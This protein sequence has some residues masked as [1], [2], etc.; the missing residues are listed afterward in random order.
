[1]TN[2]TSIW[3]YTLL[4]LVLLA[5]LTLRTWN[6]RWDVGM[7]PHPDER[8][9][10]CWPGSWIALPESW[11][12]FRD[13]RQSPLNPLWNPIDQREFSFTYGHF[14]LYLGVMMGEVLHTLAPVADALPFPDRIVTMMTRATEGCGGV[15][16]PGR[17]TIA[18]L[19]TLTI[20]FLFLLGRRVYG[21]WAGLLAATFYAFAAQ[22][23]QLSHFFAM[24]PASTTFTV[25]AVLGGVWMVQERS[26]RAALLT[27]IG[28]GLAISSKFSALPILAVPVVA[29]GLVLWAERN[30][31]E[32]RS[33]LRVLLAAPLAL[34]VA[35]L[36]FAV[37]SPYAILDWEN[38]IRFTL[39]EQGAMV[40]GVAD[41][42][43]TRQY[44]NTVPYLYFLQQQI[45]WGLWWPLGIVAAL[46]TFWSLARVIAFVARPGE[47]LAWAWL[48]PYFG[49]TGAFL[50]KF[51]R[52][53][54]PVLPFA[55]LFAAGMIWTL[56]RVVDERRRTTD[57]G[58]QTVHA[59]P[60][61]H[62]ALR[63]TLTRSL[64]VLL[65]TVGVA[66]GLFWSVA[67]VNGV[68]N[69][70]HPWAQAARWM[71]ENVPAGSTVLCEQWDDCMPW[72]LPD[73]PEVN[74]ANS[75]I[76]R[77]DWGPYEEDTAQKYDILRQK[78]LEADYVAYSSKR[79][80]DSVD[81]LP[82]RYP[83]TT[84]YYDLMFSGELGFEV[85]YDVTTP[86]RLFGIEFPDQAA[87]ES[88]SLYDHP[89][90]TVFRKVRDLSDAEF[91]QLL[92]GTWQNA[93]PYYRGEDSPIDPL[94]TALG[95]GS[96]PSHQSSGLL[97]G[98]IAI[99]R[100]EELPAAP[101]QPP[102][103][104]TS[105][106]LDTPL[107]QLP[108]VDDYRWNTQASQNT[109]LAV[110]WWWLVIALLGWLA[111]PIAFVLFRPLRDRGYLLSRALGWLLAGW[112]LWL[113]AG[114][115]VAH[116]TVLN[117]WLA[118]ALLGV[119]GLVALVWNWRE[120]LSF[121][122]TS[123]PILLVGEA[124]FTLA[125]LFFVFVR[126]YNPDIWQPW[127]GGEKFMEFAFLNGILRSPTFPPVDP[128]FAGGFINYYY[129]G[130]Y[131]V[132]YV[133]KLTGIYAEVAFNLAIPTLF[134]L[135]VVN[136]FGVAYSAVI[137]MQRTVTRRSL[138]APT[139]PNGG[140][141]SSTRS[142]LPV[143]PTNGWDFSDYQSWG[144]S[145]LVNGPQAQARTAAAI[146][147][148]AGGV[149][150]LEIRMAN[151]ITG[152]PTVRH[153][154]E[155]VA[156]TTAIPW[157]RGI[158]PALLAP[159]FVAILGNLDAF[160][161]IVRRLGDLST[162]SFESAIP[163]I[164]GLVRALNGL[165]I[166]LSTEARL[167]GYDFWAPSRV[168]PATINEF[169]YWSF[170]FA[171]LHP[172][173]IGI[174][175]SVLFLGLVLTV[176]H[177]YGADWR[178]HWRYDAL[179]LGAFS[180]LL[181]TLAAINLWELPTYFG[182]GV[183]A[184]AVATFRGSGRIDWA[185]LVG[186]AVA[187]LAGAYLLFWPFFSNYEN[188]GASG[189]GLVRGPDDLG[190]W[191]LIWGFFLFVVIGWLVYAVTRPARRGDAPPT[192]LER[193]VTATWRHLD[194][195]PR[196]FVLHGRLVRR[197]SV[198]Y[199]L[200]QWLVPLLVVV[201]LVAA[202][203]GWTVLALCLPFLGISFLLI[204]R[205][206]RA[207]DAGS[208][209]VAL[210]T[211]TGFALLAGTQVVYLRDF[212]QGGDWYRMNT[213]FKFFIQVWVLL[214]IA[215]AVGCAR[216]LWA[217]DERRKTPLRTA[218][219]E[220][221]SELSYDTDVVVV[222]NGR[223][224]REQAS[225]THH[226]ARTTF[227]PVWRNAWITGFLLL[228]LA[229]L[230]YPIVGTPAR[231]DQRF[232]GWR[233]ELG[234]LDGLEFMRQGVYFWPDGNNPIEFGYDWQSIQ[235]ILDNVQ[236]NFVIAESSEMDY[237]RAGGSRI[238][239]MTGL[240]GLS[241]KHAGEQR[242]GEIVGPRSGLFGEFW[243]TP[244]QGRTLQ[245]ID[246]LDIDLIYVGQLERYLHPQAV[247]KLARMAEQGLIT[248]IYANDRAI[249]YA[250]PTQ[251]VRGDDERYYPNPGGA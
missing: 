209:F 99:L 47:L 1:M 83:M 175:F 72:G 106:N 188:V 117:A 25:F 206:G 43:F 3:I 146:S 138:P 155:Q 229:S 55:L 128:H 238:A 61:T 7:N 112:I 5:G 171:D 119:V 173:M 42:P 38:F 191:L 113:L 123:G 222:G 30:S 185:L 203:Q 166:V 62:H 220:E 199:L 69:T 86:P 101:V 189:V 57:D 33:A 28:A 193:W 84:R 74:A 134:A 109:V 154:V 153:R 177:R 151:T 136:A 157:Q 243:N 34:A 182:L 15:A 13:P 81:E 241:G 6:V 68:Y 9:T 70:P 212:L 63:T 21:P 88:W 78:L 116:N 165:W 17:L 208:L 204:W 161:Q 228:V 12:E 124:I 139:G 53:M 145:P 65:A 239:S 176:L 127:Y 56:W 125:Y 97:N 150:V 80:Y 249:L 159:L 23:V 219:D 216:V 158:G 11:D 240:S 131:L 148:A 50:A 118:A 156:D 192:G 246:E 250:V 140:A 44:R 107:N 200:G 232:P 122:R 130:I 234:T 144:R 100:G 221:R 197:P 10:T 59:T 126:M 180:L 18:L 132:A 14:P 2:R 195:L 226:A 242:Y 90:V 129:F 215:A 22:A 164:E 66:G 48:V 202:W 89:R 179:L 210:L 181:G 51:N 94:L 93:I 27:G 4:G 224:T 186:F 41:F 251:L 190:Q 37:T 172:H 194:R 52:Y 54:S 178:A 45:E 16:V 207:A 147:A 79:I 245:L 92:G 213:L 247:D 152:T 137:P 26:W 82:E 230:A 160:A 20:F 108:V 98:V 162:I 163:G 201:A 46:G 29:A 184:L 218:E 231:S 174:P 227:S 110:G 223:Q 8:S 233:P 236:G 24:D 225:P 104:L 71:A 235:W 111:W 142:V 32:G 60:T 198:A 35:V 40:R 143:A 237:Y 167:S 133:I 58:R 211:V 217:E 87:D 67:Y 76:R 49:L 248:Q 169:P 91:A 96:D 105:L 135:T 103:D 73:E 141:S 121:L 95:L 196:L 244:D 187:Y 170:T 102:D 120:M 64:S 77:I 115:G 114:F 183:L 168:L 205:R 39:V 36:T 19:D 75:Q 31:G 85:A 149:D 214:G